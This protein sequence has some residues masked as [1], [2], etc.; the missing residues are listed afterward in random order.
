MFR[1]DLADP[2]AN[3]GSAIT[4]ETP[5]YFSFFALKNGALAAWEGI[6][7]LGFWIQATKYPTQLLRRDV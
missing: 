5:P 7:V 4:A 6:V 1:R 2:P 3:R